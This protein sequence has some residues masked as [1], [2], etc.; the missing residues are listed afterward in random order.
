MESSITPALPSD[1]A[2]RMILLSRLGAAASVVVGMSALVGWKYDVV[3]LTS[4]RPCLYEDRDGG[5]LAARRNI[6]LVTRI[7]EPIMSSNQPVSLFANKIE[8]DKTD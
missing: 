3:A 8:G 7:E 5:I 4:L 6:P 1:S 2:T